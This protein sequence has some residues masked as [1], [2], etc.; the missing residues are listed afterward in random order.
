MLALGWTHVLPSDLA[1]IQQ[2]AGN[3]L[4][5]FW[6]MLTRQH[7]TG[8]ADLS[9]AHSLNKSLFLV[10]AGGMRR[11]FMYWFHFTK[12]VWDDLSM[13]YCWKQKSGWWYEAGWIHA[14]MFHFIV[15][16][17]INSPGN[18]LFTSV[19]PVIASASCFLLTGV[20]L[21]VAFC[22][23]DLKY[24]T[25]TDT[26]THHGCNDWLFELLLPSNQIEADWWF[27]SDVWHQQGI[28]T[29]RTEYFLIFWPF[30]IYLRDG[31]TGKSR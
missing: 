6:S 8:A 27:S 26:H 12:P 14:F 28:C 3:I 4:Q 19:E 5:R 24:C 29:Q 9:A 31:C 21:V 10:Y 7:R 1:Q 30:S 18:I 25:L 17:E 11:P 13:L 16:A 2:G 22:F 15:T 20:L 23:K